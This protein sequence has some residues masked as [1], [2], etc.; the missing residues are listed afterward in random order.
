MFRR[1]GDDEHGSQSSR[2]PRNNGA[3]GKLFR[4]VCLRLCANPT[5]FP[6]HIIIYRVRGILTSKKTDK[7]AF[8]ALLP[9][10]CFGPI[11]FVSPQLNVSALPPPYLCGEGRR[12]RLTGA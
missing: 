11:R 6:P 7:S 10:F 9:A 8:D 1:Y 3:A 4:P 2:L 12:R 5:S